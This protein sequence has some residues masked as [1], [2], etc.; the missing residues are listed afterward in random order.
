MI[1]QRP[2]GT[3]LMGS[4]VQEYVDR[5]EALPPV[6]SILPI[7]VYKLDV[8]QYELPPPGTWVKLRNIGALQH[9]GQ[10]LVRALPLVGCAGSWLPSASLRPWQLHEVHLLVHRSIVDAVWCC[11]CPRL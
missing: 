11:Q 3:A 10:L 2:Q 6:G 7:I 9:C 1:R 4:H 8:T 5:A